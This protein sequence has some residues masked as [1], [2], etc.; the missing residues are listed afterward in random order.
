MARSLVIVVP[1]VPKGQSHPWGELGVEPAHSSLPLWG[2]L[3]WDCLEGIFGLIHESNPLGLEA[4]PPSA[5][6][7]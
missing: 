2:E 5:V 1:L 6:N 3:V 4:I 7:A